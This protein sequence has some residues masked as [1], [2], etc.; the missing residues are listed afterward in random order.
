MLLVLQSACAGPGRGNRSR[1]RRCGGR[2]EREREKKGRGKRGDVFELADGE[3]TGERVGG[4]G[5]ILFLV[6]YV[7]VIS[8]LPWNGVEWERKT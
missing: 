6:F 2:A 3:E 5:C 4:D 1:I 7:F 8:L